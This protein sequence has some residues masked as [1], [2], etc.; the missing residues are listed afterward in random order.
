MPVRNRHQTAML[1]IA[2]WF[3][4]RHVTPQYAKHAVCSDCSS[5]IE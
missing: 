3:S 1:N 5:A 2:S 4:N